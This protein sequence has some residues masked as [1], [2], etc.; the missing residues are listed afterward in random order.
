MNLIHQIEQ[1]EVA[2]TPEQEPAEEESQERMLPL[3]AAAAAVTTPQSRRAAISAAA[4]SAIT[5]RLDSGE[6][7]A[8]LG[9]ALTDK[10]V[11]KAIHD[12][13]RIYNK[14]PHPFQWIATASQIIRKVRKYKET[15]ETGD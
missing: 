15:S 14:N 3:S 8:K 13:I 9:A 5:V 12:Y 2:S 10:S 1:A 7:A 4:G 6:P 11:A